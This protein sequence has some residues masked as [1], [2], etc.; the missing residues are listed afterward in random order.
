MGNQ[1]STSQDDAAAAEAET[2]MGP[3]GVVLSEQLQSSILTDF[4][5]KVY[6]A[7]RESRQTQAA[8]ANTELA[9]HH[10]QVMADKNATLAQL[11]DQMDTLRADFHFDMEAAEERVAQ[12]QSKYSKSRVCCVQMFECVLMCVCVYYFMPR[13]IS[14]SLLR[15]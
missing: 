15:F 1:A 10:E 2:I 13:Y 4:Q 12:A 6:A 3:S 7:W 11:D 14:N 8:A 9:E 5:T